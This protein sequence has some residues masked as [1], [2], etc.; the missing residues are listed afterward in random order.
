VFENRSRTKFFQYLFG[1]WLLFGLMLGAKESRRRPLLSTIFPAPD[2]FHDRPV[3]WKALL[4]IV[5]SGILALGIALWLRYGRD[6]WDEIVD[7]KPAP[8]GHAGFVRGAIGIA[9][10]A[11]AIMLGLFSMNL[12]PILIGVAI[13]GFGAWRCFSH[14]RE[15]EQYEERLAI[16]NAARKPEDPAISE[17]APP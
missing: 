4:V 17:D 3:L 12:V 15:I 8:P 14:D 1:G 10:G 6:D 5:A 9:I 7:G 13:A 2:A 16:W 11:G